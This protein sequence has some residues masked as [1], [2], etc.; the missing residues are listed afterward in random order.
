MKKLNILLIIFSIVFFTSCGGEE[1]PECISSTAN[2]SPEDCEACCKSNGYSK[3]TV[4]TESNSTGGQDVEYEVCN[5]R[6]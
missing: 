4:S 1:I 2:D 6:D 3:G 5:C